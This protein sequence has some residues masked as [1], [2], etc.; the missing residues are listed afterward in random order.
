MGQLTMH[1]RLA[2]MFKKACDLE[3]EWARTVHQDPRSA[4]KTALRRNIKNL[5]DEVKAAWETSI[6]KPTS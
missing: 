2:I 6:K 5:T 4:G 1:D 3:E